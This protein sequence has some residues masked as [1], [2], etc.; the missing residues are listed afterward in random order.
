[1][2]ESEI[3]ERGYYQRDLDVERDREYEHEEHRRE[4]ARERHYEK[5]EA[6]ARREP[7]PRVGGKP[8]KEREH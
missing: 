1:M 2:S 6:L 3:D 7:S 5:G 8:S 4:E